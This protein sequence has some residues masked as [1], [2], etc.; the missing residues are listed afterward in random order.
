MRRLFM[1]YLWFQEVND[2]LSK[3]GI[4]RHSCGVPVIARIRDCWLENRRPEET[5]AII[6]KEFFA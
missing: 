3:L 2:E 4:D 5:A 6:K 1:R